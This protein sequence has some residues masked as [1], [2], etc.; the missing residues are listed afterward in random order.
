MEM[1][2]CTRFQQDGAP[3]HTGAKAEE[4]FFENGIEVLSWAP[5]SPDMNPIENC[6]ILL[7]KEVIKLP[8]AKN[9]EE[10]KER[11][12]AAW[13][14]LAKRTDVLQSLCDSMPSRVAEL[15]KSKGGPT[16]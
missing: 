10:L 4:W 5:E 2:G 11:I 7:K 12:V 14:N 1:T 8:A 15:K 6:W 16:R 3:C 13:D 9:R